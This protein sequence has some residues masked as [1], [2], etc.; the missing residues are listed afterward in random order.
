AAALTGA[1]FIVATYH[2]WWAALVFGVAAIGA[3]FSWLWTGTALIPEK[4][5]KYVG[6]DTTLPLYRS[7]SASVGW[8]AMFITM[9][10]DL[11]AFV[12]IVFGY[13]FY[14][15][16]HQDFPPPDIPGPGM[17]W[18]LTGAALI[19]TSW[20]LVLVAGNRNRHD[21]ASSF[22][23]SLLL[24]AGAASA[25]LAALLAAPY[26]HGM[27]PTTHVYPAIVWLLVSWS[28]LHVFC[29]I[30]MQLYCAA[31]RLAGCMTANHDIDIRNVTLYWHFLL[32]TV[33]ITVAVI[34]FFPELS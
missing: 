27:D 30:L 25:G 14:W 19:L 18:P 26:S 31:R 29:G 2:W 11:T 33:F 10:A 17:R 1:V 12:S 20:L 9:I 5:E 21:R 7:G 4:P 22:Y 3:I 15:T 23:V 28:A 24:A 32:I 16:V 6:L 8:W 34:A 13:F